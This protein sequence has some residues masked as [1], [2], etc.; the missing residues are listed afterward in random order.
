MLKTLLVT[1]LIIAIAMALLCVKLLVRKD[2]RFSSMHIHDSQA[3][4]AKGIRCV[5]EQ[6]AQA[7][8]RGKAL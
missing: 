2:G 3:M 6:D 1:V 5:S 7:R 8:R 4:K